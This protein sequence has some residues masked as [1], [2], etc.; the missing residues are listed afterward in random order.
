MKA[1]DDN[2]GVRIPKH[3]MLDSAIESLRMLVI[4]ARELRALI[5]GEVLPINDQ[6]VTEKRPIPSLE[7]VL[8]HGP[9]RIQMYSEEVNDLL[10]EI[11]R[12]LF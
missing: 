8:D 12:S 3:E 11:R 2:L 5:K 6:E 1:E 9:N 7:E 10:I 4:Q